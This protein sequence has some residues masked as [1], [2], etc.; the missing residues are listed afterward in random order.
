MPKSRTVNNNERKFEEELTFFFS[1]NF[2]DHRAIN[3][4]D[5]CSAKNR[6]MTKLQVAKVIKK[7]FSYG[8]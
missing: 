5:M 2:N 7:H 6:A 1:Q 4:N 3:V 8:N